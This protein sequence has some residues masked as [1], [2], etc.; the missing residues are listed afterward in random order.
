MAEPG[1]C[2]ECCGGGRYVVSPHDPADF[3]QL[4]SQARIAA[5]GDARQPLQGVVHLWSLRTLPVSADDLTAI[6]TIVDLGTESLL[7]LVQALARTSARDE[8]RLFVV[9]RGAYSASNNDAICVDQAPV[10]G[11]C[12]TLLH[13][14][15]EL[16]PTH[17]DLGVRSVRRGRSGDGPELLLST[18]NEDVIAVRRG[19]R[20]AARLKPVYD[21]LFASTTAP[22]GEA[23]PYQLVARR[24]GVLDE[25]RLEEVIR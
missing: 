8:P 23:V 12:R 13:E 1:H 25:M 7:Y 21:E 2:F 9:T 16:R 3:S 17:I 20:F 11:F 6:R 18:P 5:T 19:T 24:P 22:A 10:A 14:H 4:L 15:S